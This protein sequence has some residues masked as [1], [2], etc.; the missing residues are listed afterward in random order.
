MQVRVWHDPAA[1][2]APPTRH[3]PPSLC[4]SSL[5]VQA[6]SVSSAMQVSSGDFRSHRTAWIDGGAPTCLPSGRRGPSNSTRCWTLNGEGQYVR[7]FRAVR[8]RAREERAREE[9]EAQPLDAAV[10]QSVLLHREQ[11]RHSDKASHEPT[12][13]LGAPW[14]NLEIVHLVNISLIF[15]KTDW[16]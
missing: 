10:E 8:C 15:F 16:M 11:R 12:L 2:P 9:E 7:V 14:V 13:G 6:E 4:T 3:C 1:G 5:P